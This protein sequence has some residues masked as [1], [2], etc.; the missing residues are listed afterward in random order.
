MKFLIHLFIMAL[1]TLL[2]TSPLPYKLTHLQGTDVSKT[3]P[4]F[5]FNGEGISFGLTQDHRIMNL[6]KNFATQE[7]R[8]LD[9]YFTNYMLISSIEYQTSD[10]DSLVL[11]FFDGLHVYNI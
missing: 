1:S 2:V 11:Y 5:I 8:E 9:Y 4:T 6:S 10:A 3:N 7:M